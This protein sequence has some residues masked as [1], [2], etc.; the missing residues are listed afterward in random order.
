MALSGNKGEWSEIYVLLHLLAEGVLYEGDENGNL[1]KDFFYIIHEVFR[2]EH[3]QEVIYKI[4][5]GDVRVV[6]NKDGERIRIPQE[7]FIAAA[8]DLFL[9][10]K[11]LK[12]SF[13]VEDTERFLSKICCY[14]LKATTVD[15]TDISLL[16]HDP[17]TL[18]NPCLNFSIKSQLGND[19]TLLN[20]SKATNFTFRV[21]GAILTPEEINKINSI[22]SPRNKVFERCDAVVY[23]GGDFLY[24]HIDNPIFESN[25]RMLDGDMPKLLAALLLAQVRFRVSS[26][27]TLVKHVAEE[28]ILQLPEREICFAAY[29][30]KV[31]HLL[32]SIALG[33]MPATIW[34]GRFNA[35]GGYLIVKKTGEIMCYNSYSRNKFE[36]YLF[37]NS[38]L[39]RSS[40]TRQE[41]AKLYLDEENQLCFKLNLQIRL[42]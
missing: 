17:R 2:R 1:L 21:T 7:Q 6:L 16:V 34:D 13:Q 10:I 8:H 42:K 14:S 3:H 28:N 4:S 22:N 32:T 36:N 5:D 30:Y 25:L 26:I 24:S 37:E 35:N 29:S 19:A 41:Y 39:E 38:Y 27:S 15:K 11:E 31:K 9:K 20:A 33:M 12:G 18:I 23:A 40:T